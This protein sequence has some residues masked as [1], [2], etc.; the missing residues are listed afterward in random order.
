MLSSLLILRKVSCLFF[1]LFFVLTL[2][3]ASCLKVRRNA[4]HFAFPTS[5]IHSKVR[6]S[7]RK[8]LSPSSK[9]KIF[10]TNDQIFASKKE[11]EGYAAG[12]ARDQF[13][14]DR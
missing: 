7:F 9:E 12:I 13:T 14:I 11:Y 4:K 3:K 5:A 8:L 10:S 2:C 6:S 1:V